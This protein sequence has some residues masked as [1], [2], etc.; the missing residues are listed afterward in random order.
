MPAASH[1]R[2]RAKTASHRHVG[3][4][5]HCPR[6]IRTVTRQTHEAAQAIPALKCRTLAMRAPA[7]HAPFFPFHL[8]KNIP[9]GG[10]NI[11][12]RAAVQTISRLTRLS[13]SPQR[14]PLET[15]NLI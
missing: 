12:T 5:G 11:M 7:P 13:P 10:T 15:V 2:P 8:D 1:L 9:A 3:N 4:R 6:L 14:N